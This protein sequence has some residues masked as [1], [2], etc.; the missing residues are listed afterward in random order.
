MQGE[1]FSFELKGISKSFK[2]AVILKDV[3]LAMKAGEMCGLIGASGSGKSTLL[4]IASRLLNSDSGSV[5]LNGKAIQTEAEILNARRKYFGFIYQFHNLI[6][7][8]TGFE[9]VLISQQIA[10]KKDLSFATEL[11]KELGI[12]EKRNDSPA[13]LSGGE[14]QRFA[15]ARAFASKPAI[16]FADEPTGNL[17][18]K[19]AEK[20]LNLILSLAKKYKTALIFVTHNHNFIEKFDKCYSIEDSALKLI[21]ERILDKSEGILDAG[22]G[23]LDAKK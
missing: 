16:I 10:G 8:L 20:A 11:L 15:I 4:Y 9:N 23:M 19:T 22:E 17:D 12:F 14:A 21:Y 6:P 2:D 3:N 13:T 1:N 5:F 18:P 7:E